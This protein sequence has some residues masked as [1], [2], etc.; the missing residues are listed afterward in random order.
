[1]RFCT[2]AV[3]TGAFHCASPRPASGPAPSRPT[4]PT[5]I[6]QLRSFIFVADEPTRPGRSRTP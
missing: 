4:E 3:G 2:A 6:H 5:A 1:M